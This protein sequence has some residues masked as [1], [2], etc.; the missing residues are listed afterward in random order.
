MCLGWGLTGTRVEAQ[1]WHPQLQ[2]S[3]VLTKWRRF[4]HHVAAE[5][6]KAG[7]DSC[8]VPDPR[9]TEAL[10]QA[11]GFTGMLVKPPHDS[12][13]IS[14]QL[15]PMPATQTPSSSIWSLLMSQLALSLAVH[16]MLAAAAV[17]VTGC[18]VFSC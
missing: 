16:M 2:F 18:A 11:T 12:S 5:Q 15:A 17:L 4:F 14:S 9:L 10:F 3:D 7:P 8:L 1:G 13:L 6:G